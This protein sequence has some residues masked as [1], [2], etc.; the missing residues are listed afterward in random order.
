MLLA[1]V[2][3]AFG[4]IALSL[5]GLGAGL[6]FGRG[7]PRGTCASAIGGD[8]RPCPVCGADPGRR[9]DRS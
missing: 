1:E 7:A 2:L 4:V 3:L 6:F 5:A 9:G 8:E